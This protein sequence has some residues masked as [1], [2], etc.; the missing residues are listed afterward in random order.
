MTGQGDLPEPGLGAFAGLQLAFLFETLIV[1]ADWQVRHWH[2]RLCYM[3]TLAGGWPRNMD[4]PDFNH[5]GWLAADLGPLTSQT[6]LMHAGW[7]EAR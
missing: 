2:F 3:F 5:V 4:L 1:F 6:S 7:L